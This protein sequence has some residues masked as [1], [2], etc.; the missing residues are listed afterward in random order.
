MLKLHPAIVHFPIVLFL[1][2]GVFGAIALFSKKEVFRDICLKC[3]I[4]G[5]ITAP[6]AVVTGLL[7]EQSM[8]HTEIDPVLSLHK[9]NG[10]SLM[11]FFQAL[12]AWYWL[13]K[14]IP[15]TGEYR[16]WALC[17]L[18]GCGMVLLQGYLGGKMVFEKGMG[19]QPVEESGMGHGEKGHDKADMKMDHSAM[20]GVGVK[21]NDK[22]HS[23]DTLN[24][25]N[26]MGH[27]DHSMMKNGKKEKGMN[28]PGM[29]MQSP[30]DTFRFR[31]NNPALKAKNQK[32]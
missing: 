31:D 14:K 13:R 7:E 32:H 2:S 16:A 11:F 23:T 9:F 15:G 1:L 17:L 29:Q 8:H 3:L 18:I 6:F 30:P 22:T 19:V 10:I 26:K 28:M 27:M 12:L 21:H 24:S 4:G 5:A 20:D 25:G